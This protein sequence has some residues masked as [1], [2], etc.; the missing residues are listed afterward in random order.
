MAEVTDGL[1][2]WTAHPV[3]LLPYDPRIG[4]QLPWAMVGIHNYGGLDLNEQIEI[5]REDI[6]GK[7]FICGAQISSWYQAWF[8][9]KVDD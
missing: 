6:A 7:G 2:P 5:T 1:G 8:S 4:I 3:N 9:S